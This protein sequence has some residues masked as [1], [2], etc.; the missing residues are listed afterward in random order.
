M[1]KVLTFYRHVVTKLYE[2]LGRRKLQLGVFFMIL[3]CWMIYTVYTTYYDETTKKA[4]LNETEQIV[5]CVGGNPRVVYENEDKIMVFWTKIYIDVKDENS[6]DNYKK[7][8]SKNGYKK[9]KDKRGNKWD[10]NKYRI[11]EKYDDGYLVITV[12]YY[13]D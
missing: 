1:E 6:I 5:N 13:S 4:V 11:I 8:L 9:V 3:P 2:H 10:K 7:Y 12:R